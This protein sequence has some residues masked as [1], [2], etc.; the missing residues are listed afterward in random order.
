MSNKI[1]TKVGPVA[2][3]AV[4][5]APLAANA[6]STFVTGTGTLNTAARV[7]FQVTIP[8]FLQL[9]VG[10]P[11]TTIDLVTFSVGAADVGNS[12]P[13]AGAGGDQGGGQVTAS[14]RGNSADVTLQAT[15]TPLSNGVE[16]LD[17]AQVNT[18]TSNA[19]LTPPALTNGT[20]SSTVAA[21]GRIVNR[22]AT[23]SYSYLNAVEVAPGTYAGRVTYT[24]TM[25]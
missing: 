6:E 18:T 23:W 20:T 25:L 13:V 10:S 9:R 7:D 1:F 15:T 21:T 3:A 11:G 8:K 17:W 24:A 12:V 2:L 22:S 19:L 16:V 4:L 14:V 5:A